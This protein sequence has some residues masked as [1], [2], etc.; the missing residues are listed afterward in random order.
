MQLLW[1]IPMD[2]HHYTARVDQRG[3]WT[4]PADVRH[5]LGIEPGSTWVLTMEDGGLRLIR[6]EESARRGRGLLRERSPEA[7]RDRRL[8]DELI[9]ER[10]R[11]TWG[12][13]GNRGCGVGSAWDFG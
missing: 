1:G 11:G 12:S 5:R 10:R 3:R 9:A 2:T 4:L 8:A 7:T 13:A 6:P